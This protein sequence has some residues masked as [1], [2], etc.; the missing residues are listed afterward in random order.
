MKPKKKKKQE[1]IIDTRWT[2]KQIEILLSLI[3]T[4]NQTKTAEILQ[5]PQPTVSQS[6]RYMEKNIGFQLFERDATFK[7]KGT[8]HK[9]VPIVLIKKLKPILE[10]IV[11]LYTKFE[12]DIEMYHQS[13]FK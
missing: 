12:Y 8:E 9:L 4:N 1:I 13:T 10:K 5:I 6:L 2:K 11:I 7:K 3:E